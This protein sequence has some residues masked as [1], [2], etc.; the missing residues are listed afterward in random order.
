MSNNDNLNLDVKAEA[1]ALQKRSKQL[2]AFNAALR[3]TQS[4][5]TRKRVQLSKSVENKA[6]KNAMDCAAKKL[7]SI[8]ANTYKLLELVQQYPCIYNINMEDY[9]NR[10]RKVQVYNEIACRFVTDEVSVNGDHIRAK[11]KSLRSQYSG[12]RA[13]KYG[14][15]TGRAATKTKEWLFYKPM[16][17]L[18]SYKRPCAGLDTTLDSMGQVM[19]ETDDADASDDNDVEANVGDE[20]DAEQFEINI[21]NIND[22]LGLGVI[23]DTQNVDITTIRQSTLATSTVTF[24][25]L[26]CSAAKSVKPTTCTPSPT[27]TATVTK[28]AKS[29]TTAFI[30]SPIE[31]PRRKRSMIKSTDETLANILEKDNEA[32]GAML[33]KLKEQATPVNSNQAFGNYVTDAMTNFT[34]DTQLSLRIEIQDAINDAYKR[35]LLGVPK[36]Q[37]QH[38]FVNQPLQVQRE[39]QTQQAEVMIISNQLLLPRNTQPTQTMCGSEDLFADMDFADDTAD[40][41]GNGQADDNDNDDAD[42]S[43]DADGDDDADSIQQENTLPP[44]AY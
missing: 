18:Y 16:D 25:T 22:N 42:G 26:T 8:P 37:Q 43:D 12:E 7:L 27:E 15:K 20:A 6:N 31:I 34:G 19:E 44:F 32:F 24:G 29:T 3:K 28:P 2:N 41:D 17:F 35:K 9:R 36:V 30:A 1:L 33:T 14:T 21:P 4:A 39:Q 23:V 38:Q 5:Q 10:Y 40:T 13:A 11:L